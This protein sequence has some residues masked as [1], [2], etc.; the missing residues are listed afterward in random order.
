MGQKG[1][2]LALRVVGTNGSLPLNGARLIIVRASDQQVV[3]ALDL[4]GLIGSTI[5]L[6]VP[7][8]NGSFVITAEMEL[9]DTKDGNRTL[10]SSIKIE[11]RKGKEDQ[12]G[13]SWVIIAISILLISII[14]L[15]L[16]GVLLSIERTSYRLQSF[17][18]SGS[19]RN[20]EV[21][22]SLVQRRVG[23]RFRELQGELAMDRREL[24]SGLL[25]LTSSGHIRAV[26]DGLML[27]FL[28]TVGSF[29][30]GPLALDRS[31]GMIL[32]LLKGGA[33]LT[34]SELSERSGLSVRSVN[35]ELSLLALKDAISA[36]GKGSEKRF[37]LDRKQR[38]RLSSWARSGK[39]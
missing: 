21:I 4:K 36:K 8:L 9:L 7:G 37:Y 1:S 24:V 22:L 2:S 31:Q 16:L 20:D 28:P 39:L 14:L 6:D 15:V 38:A 23:V 11:L 12:N 5:V 27:R 26:P 17:F 10:S 25:S 34:S 30:R 18:A 35:K 3:R 29:V 19:S 32:D 13:L 33:E